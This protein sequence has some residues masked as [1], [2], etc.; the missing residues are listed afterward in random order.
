MAPFD[1]LYITS[2]SPKEIVLLKEPKILNFFNMNSIF[3]YFNYSKYREII[4]EKQNIIFPDG[5]ILALKLGVKQEK[6][7][8]FT[9][10]FLLSDKANSKKHFFIGLDEKEV[11]N[12]VKITGLTTK[13][14]DFYNP[15]FIREIE[16]SEEEIKKLAKKIKKFK[17]HFIWVCVGGPKQDIL[18]NRLFEKYNCFYFNVGAG[19]D[20]FLRKKKEA[21]KIFTKLGIEWLYRLITDPKTTRKKAWRSFFALRYLGKVQLRN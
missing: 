16:F 9:K 19:M 7:P 1:V 3:W 8:N 18:A 12:V 17:P 2:K 15:P 21:L 11:K 10:R 4:S 13:K 20:F 6:G 14:I 5:R